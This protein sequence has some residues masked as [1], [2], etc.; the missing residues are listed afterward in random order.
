[1]AGR[2]PG[3]LAALLLVQRLVDTGTPP[4]K[5]SEYW[6]L[7]DAVGD[8]ARLLGADAAAVAELTGV[9]RDRAERVVSL[10]EGASAFAFA[11][12]EVEQA[13]MRV[14]ASVD[15]EYPAVLVERL[16]RS[17]PPLLYV[18]GDPS[19]MEHAPLGIVGSRSVDDDG[20]L[21]A[22]DAAGSAVE[23]SLGVVS[24][25]AKGVD[26]LAMQSALEAGG[27]VVAVLADSLER[28]ARD[29]DT[30]RAVGDGRVC[31]CTPYK[32]SAGFT[33]ANAMGRNKVIYA[34][35]RATLVVSAEEGTGGTWAGAEEAL[36]KG[37]APVLVW[38]GE[39]AGSGND[40]LVERGAHPVKSVDDLFP[41]PQEAVTGDGSARVD[42]LEL[43]V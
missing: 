38:T 37:Y 5:A 11:L 36:K 14:I 25:G 28:A 18:Y 16:G 26:Q 41:V 8:P 30:R 6:A 24:G 7:C 9:G 34:L 39:G 35:S 32:P 40:A 21:A 17:A 23:H 42:Q 19:L 10:L 2:S 29:P 15:D 20:A 27:T 43:D 1:V 13:G 31:L 4:L 12:D 22:K 3:S 33:V